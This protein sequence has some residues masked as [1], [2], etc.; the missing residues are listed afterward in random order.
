MPASA[1]RSK[2][3]AQATIRGNSIYANGASTY[4]NGPASDQGIVLASGANNSQAAP[5]L[6]SAVVN[7]GTTTFSGSLT[8]TASTTF[9]IDLYS[10]PTLDA[11]GNVEG[12]VYLGATTVTT[13]S[14]GVGTFTFAAS[15]S[16]VSGQYISSTAT[17]PNGNTSQFSLETATQLVVS[18]QPQSPVTAGVGFGL[19][20]TAEDIMGNLVTN[21]PGG[22]TATVALSSDPGNDTLGGSV[23]ASFTAGVASFAGLT[24]TKADAGYVLAVTSGTLPAVTTHS[25]TV[26]A[27]QA[28]HAII[29]AQPTSPVAAGSSFTISA[30]A[31]DGYGNL[32]TTFDSS[33]NIATNNNPGGSTLSGTTTVMASGGLI[34]FSNLSLNNAGTGYTLNIL[35]QGA[36][37]ATTSPFDVVAGQ[38]TQLVVVGQPSSSVMANGYLAFGVEAEDA[39]GNLV[40]GFSGNVTVAIGTNPN[41]G[42]LS[43]TLTVRA[44]GGYATFAGLSINNAGVGYT[45]VASSDGLTSIT[46]SSF[47]VTALSQMINFGSLANH[48]YGDASFVVS[49]SATSG[50]P[51]SFAILSGPATLNPM[52][53]AI[54]ITGAGMVVVEATQ[55]GNATYAAATPVDQS[56]MV[57]KASLS[58]TAVNQTKAY[59]AALPTFSVSYAGFVN[60]DT[61]ASLTTQPTVT[62]LATAA[63]HVSG[64]PYSLS[65][66]GAVDSNYTIGYVSGTLTV[67]PVALSITANNQTKAYGAALPT[68]TASYTG[69]VNG[70]T[71]ANLST[72]PTLS[73]TATASSAV[74]SYPITASGAADSDY[75]IS[76]TG[77]TLTVNPATLTLT[78]TANNQNKYYGAALP[79]LTVS[80]AGFVN[81]DTASSLTTQPTV[82]TT[83]TVASPVGTYPITASGAVDSNYTIN[84]VPGTLTVIPA[85]LSI[86]VANQTKAYGAALPMFSVSYAGFVN[87]DTSASLSTQPTISTT[88]TA[89]SSVGTYPITASG[90][91]DS[92]YAIS[93]TGGTLTVNPV[94]LTITAVNQTKAYGAALPTFSVSYAGFVNGDT[95]ASL[96]TQPTVTTLATSASHV[97]G[98][99]YGLTASGAVDSNYTI[100]YMAGALTVTPVALTVTANNQTK[101]YGAALPTLT[102]SYTGFVNGD[103]SASLTTQPTITTTA[104]A[105]S[106]VGTYPITVG[107]A[108]D[109]DYTIS[110][111]AGSLTVNPATLTLTITA[112]NQTK[113][114]GAA[115][116]T[117]TV[118]YAGFVNGDTSASLTT[119]PTTTT[120]ATAASPVGTYPITPSGA[121][122]SNYTINYVAG[123]LTINPVALTITAGNQTKAYGA[124][125]PTFGVSYAGF[126][127][128]DTL[129]QLDHAADGDHHGHGRQ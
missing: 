103:T 55:A 71:P 92:N 112:N 22:T 94:A 28:T 27:G 7:G 29:T 90:A 125:L 102:A 84:Y 43:G 66:S 25:I 93:Y 91:V 120:T 83:A 113:A 73:T 52:T 8:S 59:G 40:T 95:A 23:N 72:Q 1:S 18:T 78:I 35:N 81:G 98:S 50:L 70:D 26:V 19:A 118:S 10:S 101:A 46:S 82:T 109:G 117:F 64:N 114:Y 76:Y 126:V 104:T 14:S 57:G 4:I 97:S 33:V 87:G 128:G 54:S 24:L 67:T 68:L 88:A 127:N 31:V 12:K 16:A 80:Y 36:I 58:I 15:T 2:P 119:Q 105:S 56:F 108:V 65:V 30:Q 96:T 75:T 122:D 123:T 107:G 62:T 49:A 116:P 3:S 48:T 42:T 124:A 86:T 99:P 6:T 41:S 77:G 34:N 13:N 74:G 89:A 47:N 39:A 60:G 69:L 11:G 5:T 110:Y 9:T 53:H 32:A 38:A 129:G 51:V 79:A 45:L 44:S 85:P 21:L 111:A 63:S 106:A 61:S 115:L 100:S 20:V 17:D 37:F 121:V